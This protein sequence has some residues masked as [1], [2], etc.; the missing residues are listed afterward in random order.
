MN[1]ILPRCFDLAQ[2]GSHVQT[3]QGGCILGFHILLG[4][5]IFLQ[6]L[7]S[8]CVLVAFCFCTCLSTT[9]L[10]TLLEHSKKFSVI[11]FPYSDVSISLNGDDCSMLCPCLDVRFTRSTSRVCAHMS[12]QALHRVLEY[13]YAAYIRLSRSILMVLMNGNRLCPKAWCKF[14]ILSFATLRQWRVPGCS[15][16]CLTLNLEAPRK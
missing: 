7:M 11:V 8:Q 9:L 14:C 16:H 2:S 3:R 1:E 15:G 12:V 13:Q 10:R 6:S 4:G 5:H